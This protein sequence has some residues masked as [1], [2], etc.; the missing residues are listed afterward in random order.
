MQQVDFMKTKDLGF[1]SEN[2]ISTAIFKDRSLGNKYE[3]LKIELMQNPNVIDVAGFSVTPGIYPGYE[4]KFNPEGV[5]DEEGVN[6]MSLDV[7]Y[8]YFSFFDI[9][10]VQGREFSTEYGADSAGTVLINEKA[11]EFLGWDE[12]L[13]KEIKSERNGISA[14]VIG[15]VK[16]YHA[17]NL[18]EEIKPVVFTLMRSP[19]YVAVKTH[20]GSGPEV[21][22]HI[23]K[24]INTFAPQ[25][26]VWSSFLDDTI[27]NLYYT[28]ER[29]GKIYRYSSLLSIVLACLGLFG[30][31]SFT[32]ESR[33]K[34]IG[35]RKV[36]GASVFGI[37]RMISFDLVK[38]VLISNIIAWP[39]AWYFLKNWLMN[40]A[41]R[42]NINIGVF[43]LAA[44]A[45]VIIAL[46]TIS[47]QTIKAAVAN[48]VDSLRH[49]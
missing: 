2:I 36:M 37:V 49:E 1:K 33:I 14:T 3:T 24:V 35:I 15:V 8:G 23:E 30:L 19:A 38:L 26:I 5:T 11:A 12:P 48:P 18:R 42:I 32:A 27:A 7:G 34:E 17:G 20:P 9:P 28:E 31:A 22:E 40:F 41:Y 29:T 10:I 16:N 47:A 25:L 45:A 21:K 39:V 13:G 6:M 46:A 4:I 44:V 43:T